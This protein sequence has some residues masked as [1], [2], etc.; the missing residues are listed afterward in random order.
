MP[1][2]PAL[3]ITSGSDTPD[4]AAGCAIGI[5]PHGRRR[6]PDAA[7]SGQ[8]A[9]GQGM[10][11]GIGAVSR[12]QPHVR[13]GGQYATHQAGVTATSTAWPGRERL[14]SNAGG[15][16]QDGALAVGGLSGGEATRRRPVRHD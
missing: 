7:S 4:R 12:P 2:L 3:V 14:G 1:L 9:H 11:E 5:A 6:A 8:G 13:A 16:L 15:R 10:T